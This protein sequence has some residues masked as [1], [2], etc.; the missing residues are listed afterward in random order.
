M[1]VSLGTVTVLSFT[2]AFSAVTFMVG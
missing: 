2:L 1:V